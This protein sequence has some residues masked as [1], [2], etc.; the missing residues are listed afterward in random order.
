MYENVTIN[1]P[2]YKQIFEAT[3]GYLDAIHQYF[4]PETRPADYCTARVFLIDLD[5]EDFY[6]AS[7]ALAPS[8]RWD[9][10]E[11]ETKIICQ[12]DGAPGHGYD[13]M[14]DKATTVHDN[15]V[16]NAMTQGIKIVKQ[17]RHSPEINPLD[18]GVW[19]ILKSAVENRT[20]EVPVFTGRNSEA[21]EAK[22][23]EI[24]KDEWLKID[25]F[26]LFLIFEQR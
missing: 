17:S 26:K 7:P 12:E 14:H 13:N 18:L 20:D 5:Q 8:S 4:N 23:W 21:V 15:L 22:I 2:R 1:G 6:A 19:S 11:V 10:P 25:P 3:G 9:L 24:L 16:H